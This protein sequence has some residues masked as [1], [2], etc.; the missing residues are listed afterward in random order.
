MGNVTP[1]IAPTAAKIAVAVGHQF[2]TPPVLL[3]GQKVK[4]MTDRNLR[5][6]LVPSEYAS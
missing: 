2:T 3:S 6:D 4:M 1:T 5:I